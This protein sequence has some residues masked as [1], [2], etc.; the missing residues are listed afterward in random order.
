M[1]E[2]NTELEKNTENEKI[3]YDLENKKDLEELEKQMKS[4][5]MFLRLE[6]NITYKI[7]LTSSKIE[8][9]EKIFNND[10]VI[11]YQLIVSSR[12]S[13]KSEFVGIWEVGKGI[14]NYVSKNYSK[15][16]IFNV[17]KKGIG[18]NTRYSINKDF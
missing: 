12:G 6:E 3:I 4:N 7:I 2:K 13:D 16:A 10:I 1:E 8:Q 15:N 14:L 9:I 18:V 11:K 17:L 5:D